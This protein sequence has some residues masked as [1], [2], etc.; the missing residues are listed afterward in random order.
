MVEP[1]RI[2]MCSTKALNCGG[3]S[4]AVALVAEPVRLRT[5][6]EEKEPKTAGPAAATPSDMCCPR[7]PVAEG[8]AC[9]A[10]AAAHT[11]RGRASSGGEGRSRRDSRPPDW[12]LWPAQKASTKSS[13]I[14]AERV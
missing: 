4:Q 13:E 9:G 5:S 11:G 7:R 12:P 8:F 10:V 14:K 1:H 3:R 6:S 2:C